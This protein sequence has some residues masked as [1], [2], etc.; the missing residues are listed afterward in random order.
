MVSNKLSKLKSKLSQKTLCKPPPPPPAEEEPPPLVCECTLLPQEW[1]G[2]VFSVQ[3]THGTWGYSP[4]YPDDEPCVATATALIGHF[5]INENPGNN[6]FY[7][8]EY[9]WVGTDPYDT[10]G[11]LRYEFPNG[12]VATFDVVIHFLGGPP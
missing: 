2:D 12:C 10:T 3:P 11:Q 4:D 5:H 9:H 6:K 8:A 1:T 7:S